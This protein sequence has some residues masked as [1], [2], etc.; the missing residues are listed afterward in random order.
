MLKIEKIT[1]FKDYSNERLQPG[2]FY[3]MDSKTSDSTFLQY[4]YRA[5]K[6]SA[7]LD[8]VKLFLND[9]LIHQF[10]FVSESVMDTLPNPNITPGYNVLRYDIFNA[11][12]KL[13][14]SKKQTKFHSLKLAAELSRV[15]NEN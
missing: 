7:E 13:L 12:N 1:G 15:K 14:F 11:Q 2:V 4:S 6:S 5:N 8:H 9:S 10:P 3:K